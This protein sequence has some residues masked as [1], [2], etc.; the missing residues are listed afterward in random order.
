V[1]KFQPNQARFF[2][3]PCHVK[4]LVFSL[5]CS[6]GAVS[7]EVEIDGIG[8][9]SRDTIYYSGNLMY[10]GKLNVE[11]ERTGGWSAYNE[12][13][14]LLSRIKY[15]S[16]KRTEERVFD[17]QGRLHSINKFN[18]D[19]LIY[20]ER[21]WENGQLREAGAFED[22]GIPIGEWK[23][24]FKDGRLATIGEFSKGLPVGKWEYYYVNGQLSEVGNF[25]ENHLKTG[26]WK[27]YFE[28]GKLKEVVVYENGKNKGAK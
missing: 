9:N 26:R 12:N 14:S 27:S 20:R 19:T 8:A 28:N 3:I 7:C 25:D 11:A 23:F 1:E 16:G 4:R 2:N 18:L 24:Y 13:G 22:D 6:I 10:V 5:L 15:K 17:P 21:Y